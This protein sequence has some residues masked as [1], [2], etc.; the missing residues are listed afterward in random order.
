MNYGILVKTE[1]QK[2]G[3]SLAKLS[4]LSGIALATINNWELGHVPPIDK[5]DTV[6]AALNISLT[7]GKQ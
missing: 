1:R 4:E 6:L 2:Q 7:I 5:L 3:I